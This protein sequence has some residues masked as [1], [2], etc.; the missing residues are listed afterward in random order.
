MAD[1]YFRCFFI[2]TS[3]DFWWHY[4]YIA[5][6][7][8]DILVVEGG[9]WI[10]VST[11]FHFWLICLWQGLNAQR[12]WAR[13]Y[14]QQGGNDQLYIGEY[15]IWRVAHIGQDEM[16]AFPSLLLRLFIFVWRYI[17]IHHRYMF[18]LCC[19]TP[20]REYMEDQNYWGPAFMEPPR[21]TWWNTYMKSQ[22]HKGTITWLIYVKEQQRDIQVRDN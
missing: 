20:C 4:L 9:T 2:G 5:A 22:L 7:S 12:R 15:K 10:L 14:I 6:S 21:L 17:Q 11:S 3:L 1:V 19:L 16:Y 18:G 8:T 13:R